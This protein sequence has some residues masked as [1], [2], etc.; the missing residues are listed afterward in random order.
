[1]LEN[2]DQMPNKRQFKFQI[3]L[4]ALLVAIILFVFGFYLIKSQA[5]VGWWQKL[6]SL[7]I[8]NRLPSASYSSANK[9][10][11]DQR[12]VRE[13]SAVIDLVDRVSPAVVSIVTKEV[14]FDP[15]SGPYSQ[16]AGIGTGF[17]ID[18]KG[19][20]LTNS[21]VV[22]ANS[23]YTIVL[24]D[25]RSF[26]VKKVNLDRVN[27]LA[28]LEVDAKDLPA[29]ELGDS[30]SIKV[31]QSVVAIGNALGRFSN[32]VTVGVV[33]G[34]ARQVTAS[35]GF[36]GQSKTF[37]NVIQTDA[38]LNLGNSGGP[39]LNLAG[40]VIGINVATTAGA[41][42]I[43]F[44]IPV[45]VAKPV[46]ADFQRL[47]KISRPFI[48]V[49]YVM[50]TADMASLK[51]LPEGAFV[52]RVVKG[53]P[54]EKAGLKAGDIITNIDGQALNEENSLSSLTQAKRVGDKVTLTIDRS[55]A[56]KTLTLTLDEAEK[57]MDLP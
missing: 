6:S 52:Q 26:E 51:R 15:F 29:V 16:D 33:S 37:E 49:E 20:I 48:G 56:E 8:F 55:G 43:G 50:I 25:K 45:N 9:S 47:G 13:E 21:H 10:F 1:M 34:I 31:G 53:S 28:I 40:Q 39:L 46:I 3:D 2:Q 12:V 54:A 22:D 32:T 30:D 44:A 35:G 23:D 38:A 18:S 7:S 14:G 4:N 57:Y 42:N 27:D 11:Y 36:G 41:D 19:L 5:Y 17:I 24:L